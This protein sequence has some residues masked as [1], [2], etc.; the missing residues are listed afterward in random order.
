MLFRSILAMTEHEGVWGDTPMARVGRL[1]VASGCGVGSSDNG[2]T[3]WEGGTFFV[4][5]S[6]GLNPNGRLGYVR[7]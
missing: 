4:L 7:Q 3:G 2:R 5:G 1:T 6:R